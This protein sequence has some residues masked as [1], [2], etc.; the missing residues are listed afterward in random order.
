[1]SDSRSAVVL[2]GTG[3]VGSS[4]VRA[5]LAGEAW[6]RVTVLVRRPDALAELKDPRLERRVVDVLDA[7]QYERF[8][9][10]H[11][12]AFCTLGIG[13]PSKVSKE[14]FRRVDLDGTA[15]F[16]AACKRQG[17]THFSLLTAVGANPESR[18]Y[19]T[20]LKGQVEERV[21]AE[22]FPRASFFRPSMLVTPSNRYGF[23][24]AVMLTVFP[25]IDP[26][27]LGP[28]SRFRSIK[29][30]DL[31]KAMV[32]HAERPGAGVEVLEWKEFQAVLKGTGA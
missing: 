27:L 22:G 16:A 32:R 11:G 29:V 25:L 6:R 24:Q 15:S 17:V 9:P 4:V 5:L 28:L 7:G 8:L 1:M 31:G 30:S 14:E 20:W 3:A 23:T 26:L 10:G 12:A 21:R 13:E 2:G 19:Y 18:I